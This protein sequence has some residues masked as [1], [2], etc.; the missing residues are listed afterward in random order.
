[1]AFEEEEEKFSEDPMEHFKIENEI[2]KMKLKMQFGDSFQMFGGEDAL[3][4]D[5]ENQF[6][7]SMIQFEEN[8]QNAEFITIAEK[9]G[10]P[11]FTPL[12]NIPESQLQ[13]EVEVILDLLATKQIVIDFTHQPYNAKE[14][15]SFLTTDFLKEEVEKNAVEGMMQNFIYEEFVPNHKEDIKQSAEQFLDHWLNKNDE[16]LPDFMA[17]GIVDDKGK[18]YT[19][20]EWK[21][22]VKLFFDAFNSFDNGSNTIEECA[23]TFENVD[24]GLGHCEGTITYDAILDKGEKIEYK[25]PF[26]L[27]F[28]YEEEYWNLFYFHIPGFNW[29]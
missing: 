16:G 1:M 23:F 19:I 4:P 28:T 25:G 7:K 24:A 10:N 14:V 20:D 21:N 18:M 22:K 15:Y 13:K 26:K 3:P 5:I 2:L 29:G 11:V 12:E 8:F 17:K 27:Y 9:L 6:L